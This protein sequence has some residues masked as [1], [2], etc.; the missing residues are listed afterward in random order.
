MP[1]DTS[2]KGIL[3]NAYQL[4]TPSDNISYYREF[5]EHYDDDFVAEMGYRYP[6]AIA[7]AYARQASAEDVPIADI[8]CGTGLVARELNGP[9]ANIDGMDI[10]LEMLRIASERNLYRRVYEIDLT[11]SLDSIKNGY[12]A[13]LSAGTFTHGHLGPGPLRSLLTIARSGGLFVIGVNRAHFE[14][15]QF[16]PFLDA[17]AADKLIGPVRIDEAMIYAKSGH[18]HSGDHALIVQYRKL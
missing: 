5:A 4:R 10:S 17:M 15:E 8:G 13:V 6:A 16:S 9:A 12:G 18:E 7:E 2:G 14:K 11:A 1:K 3:E